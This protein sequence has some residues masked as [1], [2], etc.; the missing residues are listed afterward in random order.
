MQ[1]RKLKALEMAL[2]IVKRENRGLSTRLQ[3]G[4][5]TVQFLSTQS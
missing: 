1:D 4:S 2:D 3:V 5:A